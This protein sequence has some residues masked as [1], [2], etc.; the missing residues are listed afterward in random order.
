MLVVLLAV[1]F[2]GTNTNRFRPPVC[3]SAI[4]LRQVRDEL[5]IGPGYGLQLRRVEFDLGMGVLDMLVAAT[6]GFEFRKRQSCLA[7][8]PN[9]PPVPSHLLVLQPVVARKIKYTISVDCNITPF[10][11]E[12]LLDQIQV[13]IENI[14]R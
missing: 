9:L 10:L 13:Q 4:E 14:S 11:L 12:A 5:Q 3:I 1:Y 2:P 6:L 8:V 7:A